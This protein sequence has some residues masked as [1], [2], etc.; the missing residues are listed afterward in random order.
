VEPAV[1]PRFIRV[2]WAG[3]RVRSS[4]LKKPAETPVPVFSG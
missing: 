4:A 3:V 2:F 1:G